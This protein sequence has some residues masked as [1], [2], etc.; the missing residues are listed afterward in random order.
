[1]DGKVIAVTGGT[2]FLGCHLVRQFLASNVERI[3]VY[4]RSEVSHYK[5]RCTFAKVLDRIESVIGDVRDLE[6]LREAFRGVDV[7]IHAAAMKH[8]THCEDHP[9]EAYMTNV[10]GSQNVIRACESVETPPRVVFVS[11]DKAVSPTTV[12]GATKMIQEGLFARAKLPCAGVR[13]G[14]VLSSTGSVVP[15]F[16]E[17]AKRGESLPVTQVDM[18]RF[19]LPVREAVAMVEYAISAAEGAP[20]TIFVPR[21]RS[22]KILDLAAAFGRK[23][24][25]PWHVIGPRPGEKLHESLLS[26]RDAGLAEDLGKVVAIRK[27]TSGFEGLDRTKTIDLADFTSDGPVMTTDEV[28]EFLEREGEL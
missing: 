26:E 2:G 16:R 23:Y 9:Y 22:A 27:S 8:I 10:V 19:F 7:V 28:Y 14:N 15:F 1:M 24:G 3:L 6:R 13:Y 17:L 20:G 4:A 11:T 18:T 25:V 12:Y 21:V 5:L